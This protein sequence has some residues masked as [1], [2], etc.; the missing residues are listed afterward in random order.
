[1]C[2]LSFRKEEKYDQRSRR[3][4]WVETETGYTRNDMQITGYMPCQCGEKCRKK[5]ERQLKK[6]RKTETTKRT[7]CDLEAENKRWIY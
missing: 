3:K 5:S 4:F 1:M 7:A 6:V 2:K